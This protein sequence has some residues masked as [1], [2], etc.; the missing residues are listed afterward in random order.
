LKEYAGVDPN[1]GAALYR[2]DDSVKEDG[3]PA[4]TWS[5]TDGRIIGD[6]KFTTS[7]AKAKY[8]YAGSAIPDVYG[9][10]NMG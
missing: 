2:F 4:Q 3:T 7:Q 5:D 1:D 8:H 10:I 6:E 9:G